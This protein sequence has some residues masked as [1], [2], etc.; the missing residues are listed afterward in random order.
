MIALSLSTGLLVWPTIASATTNGTIQSLKAQ[1]A[2]LSNQIS[3]DEEHEQIAGEHYDEATVALS[4]DRTKLALIRRHLA[5]AK[6]ATMRAQRRV[7]ADAVAAYVFGD[8]GTSGFGLVLTRSVNDTG[9]VTAYAGA[10]TSS[11]RAAVAVLDRDEITLQGEETSQSAAVASANQAVGQAQSAQSAAQQSAAALTSSLHEVTGQLAQ[12]VAAQAAAEAAAAAARARAAAAAAARAQA[13]QEAE[14]AAAVAASVAGAN[15]ATAGAAADATA[16]TDAANSAAAAGTPT[17]TPVGEN[18]AGQEAVQAAESYLGVPYVWGGAS[19]SGVDCSG[20]TMLAW[21]SAGVPLLHSAWYQYQETARVSLNDLE[22][23]D[24]LFYDFPNDGTDPVTHVAMYVG[25][26]PY[27]TQ[28]VIQA[29]E[30]GE[31]VSYTAL[32]TY[33][34]VGA[35]RPTPAPT[36]D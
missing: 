2:A 20:L 7:R 29:P 1:A 8:G 12:A 15:P 25:S 21:A 36:S 6:L 19:S 23:G 13:A 9:A 32:Y 5:V 16:A 30:T 26:G 35:G 31:F 24:L 4:Q 11:L 18:P 3:T 27:G 10:A 28:T 33:G 17:V 22:P 14:A 34:F